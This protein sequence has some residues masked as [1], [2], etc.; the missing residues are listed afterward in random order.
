MIFRNNKG[1]MTGE[2]KNGVYEQH[3]KRRSHS[4]HSQGALAIDTVHL[5][6]LKLLNATLIKK[7]FQDTGETFTAEVS[8]FV[9]YGYEKQWAE[10][11]GSQ[12]FLAEKYWQYQNSKQ[13]TLF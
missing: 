10:E 5:N 9:D 3:L 4:F 8:D 13:M 12:T 6:S 7:V 1:Q 11:D 2:L